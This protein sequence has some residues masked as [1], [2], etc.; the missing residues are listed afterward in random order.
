MMSRWDVCRALISYILASVLHSAT[1]WRCVIHL[2]LGNSVYD[3]SVCLQ[4]GGGVSL[5]DL[6]DSFMLYRY[7]GTFRVGWLKFNLMIDCY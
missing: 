6:K 4:H 5:K 2:F 1:R 3:E 7:K